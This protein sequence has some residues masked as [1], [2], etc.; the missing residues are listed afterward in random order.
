MIIGE[1]EKIRRKQEDIKALGTG[2]GCILAIILSI[3]FIILAV[4]YS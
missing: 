3:V 2:I 4:F 1:R